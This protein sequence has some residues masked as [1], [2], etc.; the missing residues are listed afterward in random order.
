MR[1]DGQTDI[2]TDTL[3]ATFRTPAEGEV[4]ITIIQ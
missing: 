2:H 1:T 4:K 3:I